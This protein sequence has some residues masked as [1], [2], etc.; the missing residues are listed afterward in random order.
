MTRDGRQA[1]SIAKWRKGSDFGNGNGTIEGC[2]GFGKTRIATTIAQQLQVGISEASIVVVVP[3]IPLM[4]Q[5]TKI[6]TS[7]GV[8]NFNVYVI[9]T[10][11]ISIEKIDCTL[12]ILDDIHMYAAD[13]FYKVFEVCTYKYIMGLTATIERMD[14]KH[15][16]LLEHCRVVDIITLRDAKDNGW[17]ADYIEYNL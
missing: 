3:T 1:I 11:V 16:L 15:S 8:T 7:L 13:T 4:N 12:L 17:V 5:W 2:T 6:L 10:L 9:N 14:G